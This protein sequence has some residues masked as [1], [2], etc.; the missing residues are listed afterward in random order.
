[1]DRPAVETC[2]FCRLARRALPVDPVAETPDLFAFN[3]VNPQAPRH[4][5]VI[6]KAHIPS[7][8]DLRP[9]EAPLMGRMLLL[10]REIAE[11][12]DF[13]EPGYRLVLNC[14]PEAG[15]SVY[16]VHLHILAGRFLS[17]PP[18]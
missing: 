10:A 4:I 5:L 6:P 15:Q 12:H 18:G 11:D 7:L 16:H 9:E 17:W 13:A 3:D 1:M 8:N 14:G 2:L